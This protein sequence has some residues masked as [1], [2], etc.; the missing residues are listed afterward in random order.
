MTDESE[1][2]FERRGA[3]GLITLN[4]PKALNALT[5]AMCL[6]VKAQLDSWAV[7]PAIKTV[8]V[9]GAGERAFERPTQAPQTGAPISVEHERGHRAASAAGAYAAYVASANAGRSPARQRTQP[10][11]N[12]T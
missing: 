6:A 7:D 3:V 2:L 11:S 9:R 5:H 1:V 8:V 10:E 4:R 12:P